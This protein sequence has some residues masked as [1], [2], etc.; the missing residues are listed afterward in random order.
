MNN[1]KHRNTLDF[2]THQSDAIRDGT[3]QGPCEHNGPRDESLEYS[4]RMN[5]SGVNVRYIDGGRRC[6]DVELTIRG[7]IIARKTILY[8]RGKETQV[9]FFLPTVPGICL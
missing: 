2:M 6:M 5:M 9:L 8:T 4:R 1:S 3:W 7:T